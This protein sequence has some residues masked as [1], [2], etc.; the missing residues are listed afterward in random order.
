VGPGQLPGAGR[1]ALDEMRAG[2][3]EFLRPARSF[4]RHAPAYERKEA[5]RR[6]LHHDRV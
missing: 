6:I 2:C 1:Q 4:E 5:C 3:R